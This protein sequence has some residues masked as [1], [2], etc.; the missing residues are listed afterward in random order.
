M[1]YWLEWWVEWRWG[2]ET[3]SYQCK[4]QEFSM[5]CFLTTEISRRHSALVIQVIKSIA[6]SGHFFLRWSWSRSSQYQ[7]TSDEPSAWIYLSLCFD[8]MFS[9]CKCFVIYLWKLI[10][11]TLHACIC[12]GR[13]LYCLILCIAK[14]GGEVRKNSFPREK[15][16]KNCILGERCT[17]WGEASI[18]IAYLLEFGHDTVS[19]S[20]TLSWVPWA[21]V[22]L[23]SVCFKPSI[24]WPCALS[25][26][27]GFR[28]VDQSM[29][30]LCYVVDNALIKGEIADLWSVQP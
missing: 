13:V 14:K 23:F 26:F 29:N 7:T 10:V 28:S 8:D 3:F 1:F 15:Y 25:V 11:C 4:W 2:L 21:F 27:L 24:K 20:L 17:L 19:L 18:S 9:I 16:E 12:S 6:D 22:A 30:S 5:C